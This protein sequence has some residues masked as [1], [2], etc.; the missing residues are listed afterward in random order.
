MLSTRTIRI[1]RRAQLVTGALILPH[2]AFGQTPL[3]AAAAAETPDDNVAPGEIIVTA[4]RK[5]ESLSRVGISV[6]AIGADELAN[7][8]INNPA[9]LPKLV[10]GFQASTTY[11]G[12]PV[13]TLRGVGFNTR[14][15]SSTAPVGIYLDEAAV[16]YPYMSLGLLHDLERVE[17]LKGPQGTLY[18]RNATGGLVN[19]VTAKPTDHAEG[20]F[21]FDIGNYKTINASAFASGPIAEGVRGRIALSTQN[22]GEYQ[23]SV[24][25]PSSTLGDRHLH[26]ARATLDF[27]NGGPLKVELI[28]DYW[29]RTGTNPASQAIAYVPDLTPAQLGLPANSLAGFG[30][31]AA[32]ASIQSN[33]TSNRVVDFYTGGAGSPI[34]VPFPGIL[35]DS[36]FRSVIGKVG[37]QLGD[38]FSLQSLTSYQ[39]LSQHDVNDA[40]G[41]QTESLLIETRNR[42]NSFAQE[43]RL[44]GETGSLNWS[45]GG[46]Y[47]DDK[48]ATSEIGYNN[49][50]AT[51]T[52]FRFV[53]SL[54]FP[55]SS[56]AIFQSFGN[57]RDVSNSS[58][59]VYAGFAN[60]DYK[61]SDQFKVTLG[62]R[63]TQDKTTN[64]GCTYETNG[65]SL[66]FINNIY[67]LFGVT[68]TLQANQCY[69]LVRAGNAFVPGPVTNSIDQKNFAWHANI[70]F[71][72]S[73]D[74]LLYA[75]ISRGFKSGGFPVLAASNE[76]QF[77]PIKQ[78]RLTSYEVGA[79]LSFA[80]RRG[81]LNLAGFYYDYKDKQIYGR[82]SDIIFG[83]LS[84]IRNA[85][86]SRLY[87]VEADLT[88]AP[89]QG[90]N[91]HASGT[92]LNS[93]IQQF[94]DFTEFG[95][96][97]NIAGQPFT[98]TP[99]F[100]GL[101]GANYETPVSNA[102]SLVGEMNYSL[103]TKSQADSAGL[104][105]F[106]IDG[107]GLLDASLGIKSP[108]GRWQFQVYATNLTNKYYWVGASSGTETVF[109]FPGMP[110][111]FGLRG[112][113]KF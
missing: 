108:Q 90:L 70:D 107:Y 10:P 91:L 55:A 18:G 22:N 95:A 94:V 8:G 5:K 4:Q 103:Q 27:G 13:Y 37:L 101:V 96:V 74:V 19:Y 111:R 48:I 38:H 24:T 17:V 30:N 14:N 57:F 33:P 11:G 20:G 60:L 23:V 93:R 6:T 104:S 54:L 25:R 52:R 76:S 88:F 61:L 77:D 26:A 29:E 3:P 39:S 32:R 92:Y 12:N 75:S 87:G 72:P 44:L 50:N 53:G 102:V 65:G 15:V 98:Y 99:K 105:Q 41:V 58:S 83:S 73:R 66:T 56:P 78:E 28:G 46:Y 64:A 51:I 109:R 79:K 16:A 40:S 112:R 80:D 89:V 69:T 67:R 47:A 113:F 7:R 43:L 49:Q 85:P 62:G 100:Q 36:R 82:V 59:K 35:T 81:H 68:Q 34:G 106:R 9:D 21:S 45:I 2:A 31:A 84:R 71:T 63:Y 110:R 42:I 1:L 97:A 86:K